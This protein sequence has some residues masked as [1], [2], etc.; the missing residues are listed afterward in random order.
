MGPMCMYEEIMV[1]C[2]PYDKTQPP[3]KAVAYRVRAHH[4][5]DRDLCP[6]K[7]YMDIIREGAAELGLI[8]SYQL[9]LKDHPVQRPCRIVKEFR[10]YSLILVFT[11]AHGFN[12]PLLQNIYAELLL[13]VYIPPTAPRWRQL[14]GEAASVIIMSPTACLGLLLGKLL[15]V[16][17]LISPEM[18]KWITSLDEGSK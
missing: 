12:M 1:V 2:V 10:K 16:S 15:E 6:S 11:V 14:A 18:K 8:D 3:V 17:G 5:A 9:W 4:S 13:R 7:R